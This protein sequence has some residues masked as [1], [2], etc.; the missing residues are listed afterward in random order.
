MHH[1]H[2]VT[3]SEWERIKDLL[4]PENTGKGRHSK[5]NRVIYNGILWIDKTGAPWRDL[6]ERFGP[7]QTV[8]TR[9]RLWSKNEVFKS[10][11]EHLSVDAD[12]QDIS[13]D[14]TSCKVHQHA[15]GAK[16]GRKTQKQTKT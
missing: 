7:W 16:K 4:P 10:M 6:P 11:F 13:I 12:M 15:A 1:R 8:Y 14:S 3:D 5:S 2:E 9:F